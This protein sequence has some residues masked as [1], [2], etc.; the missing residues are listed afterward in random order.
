MN[1]PRGEFPQI[2]PLHGTLLVLRQGR[3][4]LLIR[5]NKDPYK[6]LLGLPGG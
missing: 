1:E 3:S 6:G 5:R 2:K 4:L